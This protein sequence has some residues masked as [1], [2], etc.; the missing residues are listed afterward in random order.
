M[1]DTDAMTPNLELVAFPI[2]YFLF[3]GDSGEQIA[4]PTVAFA[5]FYLSGISL[6]IQNHFAS[7]R[8]W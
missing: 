4:K 2:N 1:G 5:I 7:H 8:E 3:G 6:K